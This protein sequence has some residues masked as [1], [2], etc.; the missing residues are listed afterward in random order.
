MSCYG[1]YRRSESSILSDIKRGGIPS[2]ALVNSCCWKRI[3]QVRGLHFN[4]IDD[5]TWRDICRQRGYVFAR[6]NPRGF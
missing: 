5:E 3:C 2:E 4:E 1:Y 6:E